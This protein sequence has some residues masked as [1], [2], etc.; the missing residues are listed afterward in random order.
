MRRYTRANQESTAPPQTG[1]VKTRADRLREATGGYPVEVKEA[2]R[3]VAF[4]GADPGTLPESNMQLAGSASLADPASWT[5]LPGAIELAHNNR[6][7]NGVAFVCGDGWVQ[8]RVTN[9]TEAD[10]VCGVV[11]ERCMDNTNDVRVLLQHR[12]EDDE[13]NPRWPD[14]T[15]WTTIPNRLWAVPTLTLTGSPPNESELIDLVQAKPEWLTVMAAYDGI[16]SDTGKGNPDPVAGILFDT[17]L[18]NSERGSADAAYFIDTV[19]SAMVRLKVDPPT[20]RH[21]QTIYTARKHALPPRADERSSTQKRRERAERQDGFVDDIQQAHGLADALVAEGHRFQ[22]DDGPD[23]RWLVRDEHTG[24]MSRA[25]I[26]GKRGMHH[27]AMSWVAAHAELLDLGNLSALSRSRSLLDAASDLPRLH[28]QRQHIDQHPELIGTPAGV[29]DIATGKIRKATS[30]EWITRQTSHAPASTYH[31]SVFYDWLQQA[32]PDDAERELLQTLA[33][34]TLQGKRDGKLFVVLHG[35]RGAAKSAFLRAMAELLGSG[36]NGHYTAGTKRGIYSSEGECAVEYAIN[37][38]EGFR[39]AVF[40][41]LQPER[42]I[43]EDM[44]KSITG[45]A[46]QSARERH[47]HERNA[48]ITATMWMGTNSLPRVRFGGDPMVIRARL[49]AWTR[50]LDRPNIH[51]ELL[52]DR[53][54]LFAWMLEGAQRYMREGTACLAPTADMLDAAT[55]WLGEGA[56]NPM[57]RFVAERL[58]YVPGGYVFT[59]DLRH[60]WDLWR[61]NMTGGQRVDSP[62]NANQMADT[63]LNTGYMTEGKNAPYPEPVRSTKRERLNHDGSKRQARGWTNLMVRHDLSPTPR[64]IPPF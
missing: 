16:G 13:V 36:M 64:P 38:M 61:G 31:G 33:G 20:K 12:V 44:L 1:R 8:A 63:L 6:Q 29:L 46:N 48:N 42:A 47:G 34:Y 51:A 58:E 25:A 41:E 40:D 62:F 32:V 43:D 2:R 11:S 27:A 37:A 57:R 52:A 22:T 55:A 28:V 24:L 54:A 53:P 39:L 5:D 14:E 21:L 18:E 45:A 56:V 4:M 59:E 10:T 26:K 23:G 3:W 30:A 60:E 49:F 15:R 17:A 7:T 50:V 35:V 19:Q 9:P